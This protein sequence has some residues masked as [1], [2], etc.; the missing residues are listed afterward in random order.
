MGA[1]PEGYRW[2]PQ[3]G[4]AAQD[5]ARC[6]HGAMTVVVV[7]SLFWEGWSGAAVVG[8]VWG[9][10]YCGEQAVEEHRWAMIWRGGHVSGSAR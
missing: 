2:R 4:A 5:G 1:R 9:G 8:C 7:A 6:A 10:C 3:A